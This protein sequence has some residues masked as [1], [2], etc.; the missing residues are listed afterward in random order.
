ME[1]RAEARATDPGAAGSAAPSDP[2]AYRRQVEAAAAAVRQEMTRAPVLGLMLEEAPPALAEAVEEKTTLACAKLPHFPDAATGDGTLLLGRLNGTPAIVVDGRPAP[3]GAPR[4]AT[5][6]VRVLATLG[7]E[8]FL[9]VGSAVGLHP[10]LRP[11]G[12]MLVRDHLNLRGDN[13]LVGP[14]VEAWGPRFPD[15]TA[16]YDAALRERAA[17]QNEALHAGVLAAVPGPVQVTPAEGAML[18]EMGADAVAAG[19]VPD[20]IVARHMGRRVLALARVTDHVAETERAGEAAAA[21]LVSLVHDLASAA[22][23]EQA[24]PAS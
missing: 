4:A 19:I 6:L 14:N 10:D 16:P 18:R 24:A 13:P 22:G 11:G 5:F 1:A 7:V 3:G 21:G 2:S 17:A 12:A 8:T 23:R 15:M 9:L 20:V